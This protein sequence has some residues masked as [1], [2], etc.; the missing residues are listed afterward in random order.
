MEKIIKLKN[1]I[2]INAKISIIKNEK[3]D[4]PIQS[5][6]DVLTRNYSDNPSK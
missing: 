2:N 6:A 5:V 1:E 4:T 3:S